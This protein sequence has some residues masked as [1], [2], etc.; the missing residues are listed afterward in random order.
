MNISQHSQSFS[1]EDV[2]PEDKLQEADLQE[3]ALL[4]A[5]VA[6]PP[7]DADLPLV[8]VI[9]V[10]YNYGRYLRQ[11]VDSVLGQ[12]Y[13]N[14]ECIIVDN[15]STDESPAILAEIEA[16]LPQVQIIRRAS[17]DGQS[18]ASLDGFAASSGAYVIFLDADDMLIPRSVE[19]H[20]LV[21]LSMRLHIGFTS[22][23]MLQCADGQVVVSTGT[24]LNRYIRSG[25]GM[26]RDLF[27]PYEHGLGPK[28]PAEG[29]ARSLAGKIYYVPPLFN[30]W[31]WSP[32]SG[33]CYR[34]D[35][36]LLFADNEAL[37]GLRTGTDMYFAHGISALCGS[38]LIDEPIFIYRIH[39]SNIFTKSAQ[40]QN[41]LCYQ[42]GGHGDNNDRT[43]VI[44]IDHLVTHAARFVQNHWLRLNFIA[45]LS[46][47]D[48]KNPDPAAPRWAQRSRLAQ[49]LVTH[50]E[51]IAPILG[52]KTVKLMLLRKRVPLRIIL[53]LRRTT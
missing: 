28:W 4:E 33:N 45:L 18:P 9:I 5:I 49:Q 48:F 1:S 39:G 22:G 23:D 7:K 40:L 21:H 12:T 53:G 51:T 31:V 43:R 8:S 36:L 25:K 14:V 26:G 38:I 10:N 32:T 3:S 47:L 15:A 29:L 2:L 52:E 20:V 27:R 17:N 6:A 19:M 46:C 35:A 50:Y 13:K 16:D 24:E 37:Y 44:L 42:P 34:R 30:Q 11:A 41:M